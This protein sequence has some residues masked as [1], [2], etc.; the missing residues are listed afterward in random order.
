[1][2]VIVREGANDAID[3]CAAGAGRENNNGVTLS[4]S[5]CDRFRESSRAGE[6]ARGWERGFDLAAQHAGLSQCEQPHSD[7][8]GAI[9]QEESTVKTVC[10]P[11]NR[12]LNRIVRTIFTAEM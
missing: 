3:S 12:T 11:V 6:G 7:L 5:R 2:S 9:G 8:A 10:A 4:A 1:M